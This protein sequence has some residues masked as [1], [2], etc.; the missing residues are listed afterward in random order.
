MLSAIQC[1]RAHTQTHSRIRANVGRITHA[2]WTGIATN[3]C[4]IGWRC[5]VQIPG[6]HHSVD[7]WSVM[8]ASCARDYAL[9]SCDLPAPL[10]T[11]PYH[12][13]LMVTML[14][15]FNDCDHGA[16]NRNVDASSPSGRTHVTLVQRTGWLRQHPLAASGARQFI[17]TGVRSHANSV[18]FPSA[19]ATLPV[20][21]CVSHSITVFTM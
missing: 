13:C 9:S 12:A 19:P 7:Q 4:A 11:T 3:V 20:T 16:A 18:C 14:N 21:R 10:H 17:A 1:T 15:P 2:P 5:D 6:S 8:K